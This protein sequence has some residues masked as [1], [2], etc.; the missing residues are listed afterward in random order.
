MISLIL[1]ESKPYSI[2]ADSSISGMIGTKI[3]V[4][5]PPPKNNPTKIIHILFGRYVAGP[6]S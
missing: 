6:Q 4:M 5:L 1:V 2:Y 3:K